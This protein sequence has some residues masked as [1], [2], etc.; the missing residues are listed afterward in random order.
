ME[1]NWAQT[2]ED[3]FLIVRLYGPAKE[4]VEGS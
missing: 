1:S 2:G 4:V 3:L